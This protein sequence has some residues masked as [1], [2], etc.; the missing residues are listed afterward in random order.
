MTDPTVSEE[1]LRELLGVLPYVILVIGEDRKIHFINRL[2]AGEAVEDV[3]GKDAT[4][5]IPPEDRANAAAAVDRVFETKEPVQHVTE[6]VGPDGESQWYS[7]SLL[8]IVREDRVAFVTIVSANV[9]ARIR[10]DRE[11]EGLHELVPLCAW[12][13][14][15]LR[16]R[17]GEWKTLEQY[18]E[19]EG[20]RATHSICPEC[21][22]GMARGPGP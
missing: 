3:V 20:N 15:R 17:D 5:G 7:G 9:T 16:G 12:C 22:D 21:E 11:V 19:A 13:G 8:P 14:K 1:L 4:H 10:A 18:I 6:V 2:E